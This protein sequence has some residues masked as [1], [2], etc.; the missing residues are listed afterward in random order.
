MALESPLQ[1][2]LKVS[3]GLNVLQTGRATLEGFSSSIEVQ[4]ALSLVDV[5]D[6]LCVRAAIEALFGRLRDVHDSIDIASGADV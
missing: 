1:G 6:S 2:S 4:I 3:T 5:G